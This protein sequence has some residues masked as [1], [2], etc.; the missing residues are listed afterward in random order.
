MS[1]KNK[2]LNGVKWT[3]LSSII[4]AIIGIAQLSILAH[5]L[6]ASDFGLMAIV[7]VIIGFSALF[8]D[9]GIS[10]SII[11][12][13]DITHIQLSSLYW[14]NIASGVLLFI[15]IYSLAPIIAAFYNE[16]ELVPIIHLLAITFVISAI[17]NQ[18]AILIQKNLR[19]NTMAKIT[20]VSSFLGFVVAVSLAVNNYG[21]YSLVYASLVTILIETIINVIIGVKEHRPTFVYKHSEITSMISFGMFQMGERSINYFNSQ[22]DVILIG[23]LLGTEA[24]GIYSVAKN[25]SMRPAQIINPIITKVTF[26]IM[27]KVQD[28]TLQLKNIYLKTINYL[29]SVNFPIYVLIALLA[30]PIIL[31]LFGEKWNDSIIILQILSLYGAFRST[32]NPVG[33]LQMAK[34]RADLGFYWNLGLFFF[35]P[36]TIY[37]GRYWG[38]VGIAYSLLGLMVFL[39]VPN[40]YFM[41]KPLCGA[42]FKEYF[43]QI[44]Q[45]LIFAIIGGLFA[46][47]VS[48]LFGIENIYLN[49]GIIAVLMGILVLVLNVWFNRAFV[50]TV[51]E[52]LGKRKK[53]L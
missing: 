50:D 20:M 47:G 8:M 11:H 51:L 27:A 30:E 40:W 23:K 43:W 22:F 14:L 7:S 36:L 46:Y 31:I 16:H 41:V 9:L 2:A 49:A 4:T 25:L 28:D 33:S 44:L 39:A 38:L 42:S 5:Y 53:R 35:I 3:S 17:G 13:Q 37:T 45:P 34:G 12:R 32:G 6:E 29:S 10:A 21:V 19:F 26:P 18:Y 48:L 1:L 15:L 52:L 24:L